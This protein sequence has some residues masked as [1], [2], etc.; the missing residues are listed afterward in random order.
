MPAVASVIDE[1]GRRHQAGKQHKCLPKKSPGPISSIRSSRTQHSVGLRGRR[2]P[3]VADYDDDAL[4]AGKSLCRSAELFCSIE[5]IR[6][7]VDGRRYAESMLRM[8]GGHDGKG[9]NSA[10]HPGRPLGDPAS[11]FGGSARPAS[12]REC[13]QLRD[14]SSRRRPGSVQA[15]SLVRSGTLDGG[16]RRGH[17]V[18]DGMGSHSVGAPF[19]T[20]TRAL[21]SCC[22]KNFRAG[23]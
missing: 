21:Q 2:W 3:G 16:R 6:V 11:C 17:D 4:R 1:I 14:T 20:A 7:R 10:L 8:R 23:R 18:T 13:G 19:E 5:A 22:S 9:G 12:R 15:R